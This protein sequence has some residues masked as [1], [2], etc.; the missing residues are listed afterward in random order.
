MY[1]GRTEKSLLLDVLEELKADYSPFYIHNSNL[2][3][4]ALQEHPDKPDL[5]EAVREE[6]QAA[7]LKKTDLVDREVCQKN[8]LHLEVLQKMIHKHS[9]DPV[10]KATLD[11]IE[12]NH[13]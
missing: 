4:T 5:V 11:L 8:N 2:I 9:A 12:L 10:V 3:R 6:A 13:T 7:I 1:G